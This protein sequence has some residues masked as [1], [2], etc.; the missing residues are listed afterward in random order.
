LGPSDV[1][2]ELIPVSVLLLS[3]LACSLP[4][5][6]SPASGTTI[7]ELDPAPTSQQTTA[8]QQAVPEN[9]QGSTTITGNA[10]NAGTTRNINLLSS[11]SYISS[12]GSLHVIGEIQNTSPN[13]RE[14]IK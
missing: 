13:P 10:G 3:I 2:R 6:P 8:Q 14:F 5:P 12:I 11:S 7:A 4:S 9:T 1:P